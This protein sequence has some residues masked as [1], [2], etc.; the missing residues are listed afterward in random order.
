[1]TAVLS[2]SGARSPSILRLGRDLVSAPAIVT[3]LGDPER[4]PDDDA[5]VEIH[6]QPLRFAADWQ[7]EIIRKCEQEGVTPSLVAWLNS[8]GLLKRCVYLSSAEPTG[9][10][11]FRYIGEPTQRYLGRKWAAEQIGKPDN[12]PNRNLEEGVGPQYREAIDG[13]AP[14]FNRIFIDGSRSVT[15]TH[16]LIGWRLPDDRQAL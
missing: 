15:Y 4:R 7:L 5:N 6:R 9:D 10:L 16:V 13:Q 3:G 11:L 8:T 2:D 1:M 12:A 14:L